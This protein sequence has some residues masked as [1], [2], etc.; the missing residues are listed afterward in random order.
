M[1]IR[2]KIQQLEHNFCVTAGA[3]AGKTTCLKDTYLGLLERGLTPNQIVAITFTEKAAEE[4]RSRVV[5]AVATRAQED[6]DRDWRSLLTQ[7]E[8]APLS[9]IHSFCASLLRE[10]GVVLGLDPDFAVVDENE[11]AALLDEMI[12]D[13]LRS[14]LSRGDEAL[15]RLLAHYPSQTSDHVAEAFRSLRTDGLSPVQA[16]QATSQAHEDELAAAGNLVDEIARGVRELESI[17][18]EKEISQK[19]AYGRN[20]HALMAKWPEYETALTGDKANATVIN[21]LLELTKGNWYAAK[22]AREI[23]RPALERLH[24][25]SFLPQAARLSD[26]LLDLVQ[27]VS[28]KM[29]GECRRRSWL[30]FDDLLL[31]SR[32]LLRDHPPVLAELRGRWQVL[33]VDEFQDVNP[34]QG[35]LVRR[36]A[37]L[38]E[39]NPEPAPPRLMVVGDRKQSIYA[40]RGADVTMFAQTMDE[41]PDSGGEVAALKE[42]FRSQTGLI[43]FFNRLFDQVFK[44]AALRD[45]APLAFVEFTQN[46]EQGEGREHPDT[47]RALVELVEV[48]SPSGEP[49]EKLS[50]AA[51]RQVEA[52]AMATYL[53]RLINEQKVPAG[54]I[55]LIFRRLTQVGVYED[56]LRRAGVGFYTVRGR[57]FYDC[58]EVA[59]IYQGLS[60]LLNPED[61]L[62]LAG[63]L[64]S[65][66]VG[67]SDEALLAL[68]YPDG[69]TFRSL[70]NSVE[71]A[72]PLPD[73]LEPDQQSRWQKALDLFQNLAPMARRMSPAELIQC[74]LDQTGIMPVLMASPAGEQKAANLRKLLET[75]REP[76]GAL[77][78]GVEGFLR[79]LKALVK[80]PP[81]DPQ[82]PL[83]GEDAQVVRLLSVHQAKGLEFPVVILPDLD[84]GRP[85]GGGLPMN[86]QG[87][88]SLKPRDSLTNKLIQTPVSR[89][90][91]DFQAAVEEAETARLFYVACTRAEERLVFIQTQAQRENKR[92]KGWVKWVEEFVRPDSGT[93]VIS[94]AELGQPPAVEGRGVAL[95]WP[96]LLPPEPGEK[97]AEGA[98]LVKR[99]LEPA[100][101]TQPENRVVRVSVSG[102]E[103]WFACPRL[104]IMT[105]LYGLDTANL[106]KI[107]NEEEKGSYKRL[108][109]SGLA[110]HT[111][112]SM[113]HKAL[114]IA[115]LTIGPEGLDASL[116]GL[117][118]D[119]ADIVRSLS[120]GVWDTDL[121][122][123][124]ADLPLSHF[125]REQP[126]RFWLP[127][128]SGT[129]GIEVKGDIDLIIVRP[130]PEPPIIVDYK[131]TAKFNPDEYRD[132]LGLY[133]LA[134]W[135]G[136]PDGPVPRT[137]LCY[138]REAGAKLIEL[139]FSPEELA[140]YRERIIQAGADMAALPLDVKPG[141]LPPGPDCSQCKL[142]GHGLCPEYG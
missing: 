50:A 91:A 98:A 99:L 17:C 111:L 131:V 137:C 19:T 31:L 22:P 20:I 102:L 126:F 89:R 97:D 44:D 106:P 124:M 33:M 76:Q 81:V 127:P 132:Q 9:T 93:R 12:Q 67:L 26:D 5:E 32:D 84:A 8:W 35:Q 88:A 85:R 107:G 109:L 119:L 54:E 62:A 90:L 27:E 70:C 114:E 138:L 133:A 29:E 25:L 13:T 63:F 134:L 100:P 47:G 112:G 129:P 68:C 10:F 94:S 69:R 43:N 61:N 65:P 116:S 24:S 139:S 38:D 104:F 135:S 41:F 122:G 75:A 2:H 136:N 15:R 11:Y 141:D 125:L 78:G 96:D 57:G 51:W 108:G 66:L 16:R 87:V 30:S 46:D 59:D 83:M 121:A 7:V 120:S 58:Q 74:L 128:T 4:M 110:Q 140:A 130:E 18:A 34:V 36:L 1:D 23:I 79:G 71:Q 64:R 60:A 55:A 39:R 45:Q 86:R 40:F 82:A 101:L 72:A 105:E 115:D 113:V 3:G 92:A 48:D 117:E 14:R 118:L 42:N 95:D 123:L 37:G 28:D 103:N 21:E 77:Q 73:W 49:E 6:R 53:H 52:T 56:A 142:A 80:A